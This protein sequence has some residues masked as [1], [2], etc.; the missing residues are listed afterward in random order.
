MPFSDP[1][2]PAPGADAAEIHAWLDGAMRGRAEVLGSEPACRR[3][4]DTCCSDVVGIR[5][6]E[7]ARLAAAVLALPPVDR[8]GVR[9]RTTAAVRQSEG[10]FDA[11]PPPEV[12]RRDWRLGGRRCPLVDP[13]DSSCLVWPSRPATCRAHN[14][15]EGPAGICD[16]PGAIGMAV[17]YADLLALADRL[18]GAAPRRW[19]T[20]A[21]AEALG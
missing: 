1:P 17:P 3:G 10:A 4:C 2:P 15:V 12:L 14:V 7:E 6:W 21:V 9:A 8:D 20:A 16:T 5:P 13:A 19:L 18:H 11:W